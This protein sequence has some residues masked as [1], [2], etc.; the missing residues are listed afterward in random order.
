MEEQDPLALVGTTV[1]ERYA[2]EAVVG[3]GGFGVVY[4]AMHL[5]WKRPVAIKVFKALR[6]ASAAERD[7]M[8][9]AFNLE[10]ALLAEL[11]ER[12]AAIVQARDAGV[13]RTPAG[14]DLPYMVLEWLEGKSL[15]DVLS[16]EAARGAPVRT[17]A[18]ARDL[19]EP[20]AVALALAHSRGVAHRD[21]KPANLFLL[22]DPECA[23]CSVKLLDFGIAKVVA[24]ARKTS[25][26]FAK[27]TARITAF[28][29]SYGAPEQFS[30]KHGATG[31]WTDVFALALVLVEVLTRRD[32]L[33]GDDLVEL[34]VASADAS[35]RPTPR[36]LG[37]TVSDEVEA[38]FAKALAVR[39]EDRYQS[40]GHFWNALRRGLGLPRLEGI[41][42][43]GGEE[44]STA[45]S[46]GTAPTVA[47][48]KPAPI[49]AS[50]RVIA[51]VVLAALVVS[52]IVGVAIITV[53]RR[54][55][56]ERPIHAISPDVPSA[57]L[58][59]PSSTPRDQVSCPTGMVRIP[60]GTFFMGADDGTPDERPAHSV[61]LRPF[62]IDADEV[63][64][65]RYRTCSDDGLCKRA[66]LRNV[67][68][69]I[70][71]TERTAFDPLCNLPDASDRQAHPVNCV[72]WDMADRFCRAQGGRL[73]T[74]AEWELAARGPDGRR[75]PWGDEPPSATLLN[76][77][78]SECLAWGRAHGIQE[79]AMFSADDGWAT[80]APV[81]SFPKGASRYGVRDVVGNVWEWVGDWFAPYQG[82]D[83]EQPAG[84]PAGDER[85]I[86]GGAWNGA[87]PSWVRP[88]FRYRSAPSTRSYAIGF[89]CAR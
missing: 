60:G 20:A 83:V 14:E 42:G 7:K 33:R 73:P 34:A 44:P 82:A 58:A 87:E 75:Y 47:A 74:E 31:P 86:R 3:E 51:G 72:D 65:A 70:S 41:S 12:S 85:V 28:T 40:A 19:L 35:S 56:A 4:R 18:Q 27:T 52:G 88:T 29:P 22:G 21:V 50:G 17:I 59:L 2:V 38:V 80:T 71:E 89:R 36:S 54:L 77:C 69:D 24:D 61:K 26:A 49:A 32:P 8:V 62:C 1:A 84:P 43:P 64:V 76:A 5:L 78:G 13:L 25:G 46:L 6:D 45:G 63:T 55:P 30:R 37:A 48:A 66:S 53:T 23:G 68:P 39:P 11:S 15:A 67:W 57:S 81:G 10:G 16:L 9:E 79:R